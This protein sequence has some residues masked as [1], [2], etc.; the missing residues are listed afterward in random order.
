MGESKTSR[1]YSSPPWQQST[2]L[3]I[4]LILL[5]IGILGLYL[6][7]TLVVPFV[8]SLL[9]AY[10][11]HPIAERLERSL[12]FRRIWSTVVIFLVLIVL[13]IGV[14]TGLGFAFS[15]RIGEMATDLVEISENLPAQIE[16]LALQPFVIG[17]YILD[18]SETNMS[19]FLSDI[20]SAVSPVITQA[21]SLL[22]S[23]AAAAASTVSFL[24]LVLVIGFYLLMDYEKIRPTVG[25]M[26]PYQ[27]RADFNMMTDETSRIWNAFLRGQSL[28]ALIMF[29]IVSLTMSI[30]GVDYPFVLGL[31][32]GLAEFVPWFGPFIAGAAA[33]IV[34][35]F[36]PS[37]PWQ[38]SPLIFT[39]I[40]LI[41]F[42]IIQQIESAIL[43]P[44]IIGVSLDLHPLIVFLAIIGGGI[45]FGL[46]GILLAAPLVA[47][48]RLWLGYV[49][50]KV[51]GLDTP[52]PSVLEPIEVTQPSARARAVVGGW[53]SRLRQGSP[54]TPIPDPE[55][56]QRDDPKEK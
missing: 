49:Y 1:S 55:T 37:N 56:T 29:L 22:G 30:L 2:R 47:T 26:V 17:P 14:M 12:K 16:S 32:A 24:V 5:L 19:P 25:E 3:A 38:L 51:V 48:M 53:L 23:V 13:F 11:F 20:T 18:L 8:I 27:A 7:R 10:F 4:G 46:V 33:V 50:R 54:E 40:V 41:V 43:A 52:P 34:A 31:I 39:L 15:Q 45:L 36:Q 35:F 9:L 42:L 21:G 28:L 6:L 44:K